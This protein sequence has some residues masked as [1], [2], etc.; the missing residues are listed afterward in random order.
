M[1]RVRPSY[2]FAIIAAWLINIGP[3]SAANWYEQATYSCDDPI[4]VRAILA[5]APWFSR[6]LPLEFVSPAT[7]RVYA[8]LHDANLA[9]INAAGGNYETLT[10]TPG[11]V[12]AL[13]SI[14]SNSAAQYDTS[15]LSAVGQDFASDYALELIGK[16]FTG[17]LIFSG[18]KA[19]ISGVAGAQAA[20]I[21]SIAPLIAS[22]GRL[23]HVVR[24]VEKQGRHALASSYVYDVPVGS[25]QRRAILTTCFYPADVQTSHFVTNV[26]ANDLELRKQ[27]TIWKISKRG[28]VAEQVAGRHLIETGMDAEWLYATLNDPGGLWHGR[29]QRISRTGGPWEIFDP[30]SNSWI[31]LYSKIVSTPDP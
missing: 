3:V 15:V 11:Q 4:N 23:T 10:L 13:R 14:L 28:Q 18:F 17:S 24:L 19:W 2:I 9:G 30:D 1:G 25:E 12:S 20:Q 21:R 8:K 29:R 5:N 6:S 27:G 7:S 16:T 22:G 26:G 31:N